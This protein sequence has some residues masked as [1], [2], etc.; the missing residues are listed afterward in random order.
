MVTRRQIERHADT[1]AHRAKARVGISLSE[2]KGTTDVCILFA[3]GISSQYLLPFIS[4]ES[5]SEK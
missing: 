4:K 2:C 1:P 3:S 5:P